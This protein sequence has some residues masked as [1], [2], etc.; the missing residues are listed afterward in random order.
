[1]RRGGKSWRGG[2]GGEVGLGGR[3]SRDLS[4]V[5]KNVT[6]LYIYCLIKIIIREIKD[7]ASFYPNFFVL[8]ILKK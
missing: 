6:K 8:T 3:K 1:V 5:G 2:R 7:L 4:L